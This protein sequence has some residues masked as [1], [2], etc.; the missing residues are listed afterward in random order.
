MREVGL[1]GAGCGKRGLTAQ[2]SPRWAGAIT[3]TSEDSYQLA[4][5]DL[6]ANV[7]SLRARVKKIKPRLAA[8]AG[9][10]SGQTS[11][12]R[13]AVER[14]EK[15]R[16]LQVLPQCRLDAEAGRA[17]GTLSVCQGGSRMARN[18]HRLESAG[19]SFEQWPAEWEAKRFFI[20]ADG[21]KA[22]AWGNE[23]IRW[24]PAQWRLSC[25]LRSPTWRT[26]RTAAPGC[27]RR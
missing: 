24:P 13:P 15:Q 10:K 4:I 2:G 25:R 8:P 1:S 22:K 11:G 14:W 7:T 17:S 12:S 16:R 18:R 23:T 27:R 21:E 6:A 9:G 20:G 26:G 5:R 3:R 19:Q